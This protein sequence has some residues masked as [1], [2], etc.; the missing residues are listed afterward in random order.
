M[1]LCLIFLYSLIK[2]SIRPWERSRWTSKTFRL[3][4]YSECSFNDRLFCTKQEVAMLLAK[5]MEWERNCLII[6]AHAVLCEKDYWI[7]SLCRILMKLHLARKPSLLSIE[8][9][10]ATTLVIRWTG[11][12]HSLFCGQRCTRSTM[13]V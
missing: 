2:P 6:P 12:T 7:F 11:W 5:G 3:I 4:T 1:V 10:N 9:N 8:F 13:D